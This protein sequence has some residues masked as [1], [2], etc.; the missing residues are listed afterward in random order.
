MQHR[1]STRFA[2]M[3]QK[4]VACILL[5]V[6]PPLYCYWFDYSAILINCPGKA[7]EYELAEDIMPKR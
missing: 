6:F 5:P 2:A 4:Q 7:R 3:L 1:F